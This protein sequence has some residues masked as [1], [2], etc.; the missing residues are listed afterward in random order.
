[1]GL[2]HAHLA[3]DSSR[4]L[5]TGDALRF[6]LAGNARFTLVSGKTGARFTFRVAR[7][8]DADRRLWF[9]SV[10]SGPNNEAD[11][12]Y[13]GLIGDDRS[14]RL[15]KKSRASA[16]A[17]SVRAFAWTLGR[18]VGSRDIADAQIWHEG[19]CGRCG[20]ALTVPES[21]ERGLGPECAG[22]E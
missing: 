12:S 20:R 15:T 17:P 4:Q 3:A 10:L 1:M 19:R 22:K 16:D 14:F 6:I 13:L 18:L 21:I 5:A 7:A 2:H 11:F 8:K 9:V